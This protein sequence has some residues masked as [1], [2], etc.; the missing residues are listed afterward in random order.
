MNSISSIQGSVLRIAD[1]FGVDDQHDLVMLR[2]LNTNKIDG[3]SVFSELIS[4]PQIHELVNARSKH[5][6]QVGLHFN[7]THGN[8]LPS[9][10]ILL[11][12]SILNC[13]DRAIITKKINS[14]L[15]TFKDK[16]GFMPDFVDGHQH[17]HAFPVINKVVAEALASIKFQGWVRNIG[18]GSLIG[19]SESLKA[20]LKNAYFKKFIILETLGL[21]HRRHLNFFGIPFNQFFF[22]LM[23]LDSPTKLP[24]ALLNLYEIKFQKSTVI[25]CHP[26][27]AE[28]FGAKDHPSESRALEASFLSIN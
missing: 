2:L 11:V 9:V 17:V 20:S 16:F 22:G 13:I 26:G 3:V 7:L 10:S 6:I 23:P 28:G 27:S 4:K 19:W 25:M 15:N 5:H 21:F 14:Q 18:S 24:I 12:R 1:D 8:F